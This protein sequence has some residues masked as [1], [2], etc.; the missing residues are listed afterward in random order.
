MTTTTEQITTTQDVVDHLRGLIREIVS[1]Y[2]GL[3]VADSVLASRPAGARSAS[4]DPAL[5]GGDRMVMLC[6]WS[7]DA[8]EADGT[9]HPVQVLT[10]WA[11]TLGFAQ[12]GAPECRTL[13]AAAAYLQAEM[14]WIVSSG[15][16]EPFSAEIERTHRRLTALGLPPEVDEDFDAVAIRDTEIAMARLRLQALAAQIPEGTRLTP[17]E[18]GAIWPGI[19]GRIKVAKHRSRGQI[20]GLPMGSDRRYLAS[21]LHAYYFRAQQAS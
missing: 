19:D 4:P 3:D 8:D 20:P 21:D 12:R 10:E 6:P 18:A 5:P 9:V 14:T 13:R 7:G 17:A 11:T 1:M 2:E 15:W 16:R